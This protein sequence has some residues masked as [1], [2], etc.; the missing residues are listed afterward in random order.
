MERC[1]YTWVPLNNNSPPDD[2]TSTLEHIIPYALGGCND[3]SIKYCSKKA[4]NDYGSIIDAQ[5]I[6]LP[7]V[8]FKRHFFGL[9]GYSGEVPD[10]IFKGNCQEI[11]E[12]CDI[13]FP[14]QGE[15]YAD[16]G[17]KCSGSLKAREISFSGSESRF[18][19]SVNGL[20]KK[21]TKQGLSIFSKESLMCITNFSEAVENSQINIGRE[22]HFKIDFGFEAFFLPWTR[23]LI[24]IALG[25]GAYALGKTWA[26]G[27]SADLLRSCL[28][29]GIE[30]L[31]GKGLRG[32]SIGKFE[33]DLNDLINVQP[34]RHSLAV[35]PYGKRM[36]ALIS[37]FGGELFDAVIDLGDGPADINLVNE[38]LPQDWRCVFHIDPVSR[39]MSSMTI[40][41][42]LSKCDEK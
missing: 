27:S 32:T 41:D 33:Q 5:F 2:N 19:D 10:I 39:K 25:L 15:P 36:I 18:K 29:C 4:N 11:G 13:I 22:L 9:K 21:A 7:V 28:I 42:V 12:S 3:F 26:F 17:I 24:K 14:Y 35:L 23:G 34:N 1:V 20:I 37:L 38:S 30:E 6:A 8:G 16:F 31:I 40:S